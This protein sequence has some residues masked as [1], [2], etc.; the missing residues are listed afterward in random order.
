MRHSPEADIIIR[1]YQPALRTEWDELAGQAKNGF[2]IFRRDFM[3]YHADRFT[4]R[5]LLF[6]GPDGELLALFPAHTQNRRLSSHGGLTYGGLLFGPQLAFEQVSE[7]FYALLRYA[8]RSGY[9]RIAYKQAPALFHTTP[10]PEDEALFTRLGLRP[11]QQALGAVVDLQHLPRFS[12]G[13]IW[14]VK[15]AQKYA[16][17]ISRAA[18][19][20]EFWVE[21]LVPHLQEKFGAKP[22][23]SLAEIELLAGRFPK[24]IIQY[25]AR[26]QGRLVAGVTL[27]QDGPRAVAQYTATTAE[28]RAVRA[29]SLLMYQL[30]TQELRGLRWLGLGTSNAGGRLNESLLRW[31]EGWGARVQPYRHYE[32]DTRAYALLRPAQRPQAEAPSLPKPSRPNA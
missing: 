18:S 7:C 32:L 27:F 12:H 11:T 23:H 21:V 20:H 19:P 4:D 5:S 16:V 15:K 26:L 10:A 28:G 2:F 24:N 31:K 25:E 29:L 6:Y 3:E 8:Y 9:Q 13:H 17:A 1:P 14:G 22:T 30:I